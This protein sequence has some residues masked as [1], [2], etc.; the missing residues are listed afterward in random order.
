MNLEF[1]GLI[2]SLLLTLMVFS[3]LLGDNPLFKL[4]EHIFVGVSVGYAVLVIIHQVLW[5]SFFATNNDLFGLLGKVPPAI[6]CLLLIFKVLPT[7]NS[8]SSSLGSIALAFLVGVGAALAIAGAVMGTL[9]PQVLAVAS[10]DLSP[11][12]PAYA[13]EPGSGNAALALLSNN[14]FL[15]NIITVIGT[16]GTLFYFTFTYK[17]QGPLSGFR[18]GFVNFWAGMGRWVILITFGALFANLVSSRM[19]LLISRIQFLTDSFQQLV[20]G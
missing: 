16:I 11:A 5:P 20:G 4:A 1:I 8:T 6:L 9:Y 14:A 3:Y 13:I 10:T 19:A 2:V 18:E 12:N 17:P 7:Q 15:S